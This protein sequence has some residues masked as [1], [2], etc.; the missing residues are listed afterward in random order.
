MMHAATAAVAYAAGDVRKFDDA[1]T[2]HGAMYEDVR[3]TLKKWIA[4]GTL[5]RP[6]AVEAHNRRKAAALVLEHANRP[7]VLA[8]AVK[9]TNAGKTQTRVYR[10]Y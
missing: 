9:G 3:I 2:K 8:N 4:K 7:T 6:M 10:F 1:C 5:H